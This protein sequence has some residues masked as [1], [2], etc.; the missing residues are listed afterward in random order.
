M[1]QIFY[2]FPK[3]TLFLILFLSALILV[4]YAISFM[5]YIPTKPNPVIFFSPS[6]SPIESIQVNLVNRN[7]ISVLQKSEIGKTTSAEVEGKYEV[8]KKQSI[9]NSSIKY[10]LKSTLYARPN[11]IVF[12]DGKASLERT[13]LLNDDP[14]FKYPKSSELI[15]KFGSP[16]KVM[17]GS[18]F[19]G[20]NVK[21]YIYPD[22]GLAFIAEEG[23]ENVFE[24]QTFVPLGFDG[25]MQKYGGDIV[26]GDKPA[27]HPL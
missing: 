23:S 11:E 13:I 27:E 2:L 14:I 12:K 16:K 7:K 15:Q 4:L 26:G 17:Q 3:K 19:Y 25:Y 8:L 24:I 9:D 10:F 22:L 5:K 18:S 20:H 1:K 6:P 21:T